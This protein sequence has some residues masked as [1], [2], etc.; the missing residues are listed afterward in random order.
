MEKKV[1]VRC[2][3]IH[4]SHP[5]HTQEASF[6]SDPNELKT[7]FPR[8]G[9]PWHLHVALRCTDGFFMLLNL[10]STGIKMSPRYTMHGCRAEGPRRTLAGATGWPA[11]AQISIKLLIGWTI[12]PGTSLHLG[13]VA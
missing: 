4:E 6:L 10:V 8:P 12:Q 1:G 11:L 3:R 5:H 2:G 9:D 7:I 13:C